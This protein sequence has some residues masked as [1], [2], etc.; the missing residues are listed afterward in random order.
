[1]GSLVA[2]LSAEPDTELRETHISWAFLRAEEVL[3]VKKPV[4]LG[5]LDYRDPERR[6]GYC[7]A[8]VEL[9]RRL[10]PDV[11]LDVVPI[12][13]DSRGVHHA[14]V[15]GDVGAV[16][17]AVRMR[18]LPDACRA[19]QLLA[20]GTLG[21]RAIDRLAA[22]L[23]EFHAACATDETMAR[24][25]LPDTIA[26]NVGE[27]FEQT[28][29]TVLE[30][31]RREEA[32]E[33]ERRQLEFLRKSDPLLR[34][35][36][37]G[38]RVRDGHGDLRLEHVY[39]DADGP[40]SIHVLDCIEFNARFRY[41]DVAA[42]VAFLSMDLASHGRVD[43]A[44]RLLARY[45]LE[46]NDYEL[47]RVIDFYEGYR[48]YV[49][50]KIAAMIAAAA[51]PGSPA[52]ERAREEARRHFVLALATARPP[53][54]PPTL[55]AVGGLIA[56]G[57]TTVADRIACAIGAAVVEADRTRKHLLGV[58]PT[59]EVHEA[60]WRG[61][62]DP[63]FTDR[64]YDD[65]L[66]RGAD[67]LA[68]SRPVVIDASF[69]SR[70][71]RAAARAFARAH[72]VTFRFVECRAG[73]DVCLDRLRERTPGSTASDGRLEIFDA[74]A[75]EADPVDELAA[76][77]HVVLDTTRPI[78]EVSADLL[79]ALGPWP[80]QGGDE[81]PSAEIDPTPAMAKGPHLN[82]FGRD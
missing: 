5:F 48:A 58:A 71:H 54:Q 30:H 1:M 27:N 7:E 44:E 11:Y 32:V 42:D 73:R 6:R 80:M 33:I 16:D 22:R 17:W 26:V 59:H 53:L 2:D 18:R 75:A 74:F 61:A 52:G 76:D 21:V 19:D 10:A 70:A 81:R 60:A 8:E 66:R 24:F 64:V 39:F 41:A 46:S 55:I 65:L 68:S 28:R 51:P 40:G 63:T 15:P 77:E 69:R 57:K 20:A 82:S 43:L 34:A 31:L 4:D 13:R 14:G 12:V 23:V 79:Q 50:A 37:A 29:G 45:A 49:R 9:N 67:V 35:R 62:Y 72:G 78:A 25:G 38:G 3:K 36:A 47:Y 56:T